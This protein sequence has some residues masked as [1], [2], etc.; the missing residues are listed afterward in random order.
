MATSLPVAQTRLKSSFI[1]LA[2]AVND[3]RGNWITLGLVLA[4]LVIIASLC[5]LPDALNIQHQLAIRFAPGTR[6]VGYF[7]IQVPYAPSAEEVPPIFP[8]WVIAIFHVV[9]G[10]LTVGVNLVVLCTIRRIQTGVS[11]PRVLNEAI[12]IYR[13]ALALVPAFFLVVLLQLLV[14]VV[15]LIL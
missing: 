11:H 5:L 10:I 13:E 1:Y 2:N 3:L 9:L 6:S 4:P 14:V 12:Q 7:P 15:G 8:A